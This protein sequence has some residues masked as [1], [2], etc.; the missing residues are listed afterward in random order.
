M[1]QTL[2]SC[3]HGDQCYKRSESESPSCPPRD[4]SFLIEMKISELALRLDRD[5]SQPVRTTPTEATTVS[6]LPAI[7]PGTRTG[8]DKQIFV[9][10]TRPNWMYLIRQLYWGVSTIPPAFHTAAASGRVT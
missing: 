1:A 6:S 10:E 4:P 3:R 9:A 5:T 7:F 8:K 2:A